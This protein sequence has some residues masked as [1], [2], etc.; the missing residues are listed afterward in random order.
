MSTSHVGHSELFRFADQ[1]VNLKK[2]DVTHYRE[3]VRHLREKLESHIAQHP[4]FAVKKM[5]LSG[6][7]AKGT[8]L[9]SIDDID[10]AVY[11]SADEAPK[12]VNELI[13]WLADRLRQAYP[14]FKPEQ[15]KEN[16]YTVTVQYSQSG[17][18]VDVV[19]IFYAGDPDWK[20]HMIAKDTGE[21]VMTSIHQHLEF[22]R[23]R[24]SVNEKH[25]A[26]IV[27]FLKYWVRQ[28]KLENADFRFKSFMIELTVAHLADMGY[29]LSDYP[30]SLAR[31]FA[32]IARDGFDSHIAFADYYDPA[33]CKPQHV[34][35]IWD[36]VNHENNVANR[37]TEQQRAAI[38]NAALEAGDAIDAAMF[39]TTKGETIRHWQK[40]FG[41]AFDA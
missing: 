9:K 37:Y 40:V 33:Q 6:S 24:K 12:G 10:V 25:F 27:R 23:R 30:E 17:L 32:H 39:A 28:R 41:P 15:V 19:P 31:I 16:K 8:A 18:R 5:L 36:P 11:I 38:V 3:Q 2:D 35:H 4:E 22:I 20:G 13:P 26:Q 34:M 7:L 1:H 29:L 21:T 14:N